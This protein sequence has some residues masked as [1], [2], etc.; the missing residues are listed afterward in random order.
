VG[1]GERKGGAIARIDQL[2][3][4]RGFLVELGGEKGKRGGDRRKNA[5]PLEYKEAFHPRE[6]WREWCAIGR[7]PDRLNHNTSTNSANTVR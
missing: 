6:G 7:N 5:I 2:R 3:H 4:G 1:G